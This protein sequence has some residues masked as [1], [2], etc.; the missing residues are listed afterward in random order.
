MGCCIICFRQEK[1]ASQCFPVGH[2][3]ASLTFK[4]YLITVFVL[5][6]DQELNIEHLVF[7]IVVCLCFPHN[8]AAYLHVNLIIWP[9]A[10][11][12]TQTAK[13]SCSLTSNAKMSICTQKHDV[14]TKPSR[15]FWL[16]VFFRKPAF[17]GRKMLLQS[18]C[19]IWSSFED[20]V[21][22]IN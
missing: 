17:C 13:V 15:R 6:V 14:Q 9:F 12:S 8:L 7:T 11:R 21:N 19:L 10:L 5:K 16:F 3:H 2:S 22:T 20:R 4:N 1:E 18:N